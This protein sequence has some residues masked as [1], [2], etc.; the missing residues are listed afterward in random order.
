MNRTILERVRCMLSF[1]GLPKTFWAEAGMT[2]V[3]LINRCPST[4]ID[5]KTPMEKWTGHA[6]SYEHLRIFGCAAFAHVK[7]GKLDP[8]L[9]RGC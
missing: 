4:A 1:S 6:S 9:S 7:Q 8:R 5:L 2:A 3:Y